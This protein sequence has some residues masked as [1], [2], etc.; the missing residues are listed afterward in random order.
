[1]TDHAFDKLHG[2]LTTMRAELVERLARDGIE[3]GTLT[4][5][6]GVN[7]AIEACGAATADHHDLA[8]ADRVILA[9]D[10]STIT[11]ALYTAAGAI[12]SASLS[13]RRTVALAGELIT[14]ALQRL[15]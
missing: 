3:G 4:L 13:P 14:A 10:G 7:A 15:P 8:R 12:G 6:P 2:R 1:M 5:L 9:D 11:L